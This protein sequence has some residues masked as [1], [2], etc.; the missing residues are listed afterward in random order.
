[1]ADL[2]SKRIFQ[3][4]GSKQVGNENLKPRRSPIYL[5]HK[6]G[7]ILW[8]LNEYSILTNVLLNI[9]PTQNSPTH[10][11]SLIRMFD[12][13]VRFLNWSAHLLAQIY[14]QV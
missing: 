11:F 6:R 10:V 4:E 2:V 14:A 3:N 8:Q 1:M 9:K 12:K 5:V 7:I 13:L